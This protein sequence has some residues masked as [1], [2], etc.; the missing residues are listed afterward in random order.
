MSRKD[1]IKS[2]YKGLG[3][4]HSFYDGQMLGTTRIGRWMLRH[5]WGMTKEDALEYEAMALEAI[6]AGFSGRLLEVPVGT[7]VISMPVFKTLPNADITC[8]DY[9]EKMM[10]AAKQRAEAMRIINITFQRGDVGA[11]PFP[12]ESFDVVV[13]LNGFHAFPDKE[14]AYKETHRVLKPGG[15]FILDIPS[16]QRR[17][18]LG[19]RQASWHGGTELSTADV[20]DLCGDVFT[21]R[22]SFGVLFLPVH[23]LP[24]GLRRTLGGLDFALAN[25]PLKENSSYLIYELVKN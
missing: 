10:A 19:H 5:V 9:S 25:G 3:K 2:A 12:D 1:E 15:R 23:K 7:G 11:L 8:L 21:L 16:R 20:R 4:A 18:R 13:S 6:P 17:Q 14:A 22:R 24:E